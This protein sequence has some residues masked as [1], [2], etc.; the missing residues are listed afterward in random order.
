MC[1]LLPVQEDIVASAKGQ[2]KV[3]RLQSRHI[4]MLSMPDKL[5]EILVKEADDL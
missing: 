3:E 1:M 5:A 4:P 2:V